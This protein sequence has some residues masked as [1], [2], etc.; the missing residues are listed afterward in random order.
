MGCFPGHLKEKAWSWTWWRIFIGKSFL[1]QNRA[2]IFVW[3]TSPGSFSLEYHGHRW[4]V[5]NKAV[6]QPLAT[7]FVCLDVS[8]VL[9]PQMS[10]CT[11]QPLLTRG[12]WWQLPGTLVL[13]SCPVPRTPSPSARWT[14][15]WPTRCWPCSTLT[16][17]VNACP[18]SVS[19]YFKTVIRVSLLGF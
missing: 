7:E 14:R 6:T 5:Y 15:R 3:E 18:S 8:V 13:C 10:W 17:T 16:A 12:L 9:N 11:R 4:I 1:V 19:E 2:F